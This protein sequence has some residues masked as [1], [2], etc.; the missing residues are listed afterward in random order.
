MRTSLE[1][2]LQ[3]IVERQLDLLKRELSRL[4]LGTREVVVETCGRDEAG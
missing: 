3:R 4:G 2:A 1:P